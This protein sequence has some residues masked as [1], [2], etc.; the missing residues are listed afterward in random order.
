MQLVRR[1]TKRLRESFNMAI[2]IV[3]A[4]FQQASAQGSRS[5]VLRPLGW[6]AS[7]CAGSLIAL[8]E[9]KAAIWLLI[10][11]AIF[12]SVTVALYL[13][14]YVYCLLTDKE[15]LRTEKYSIQKM[16]IEKGYY[17]D[18]TVGTFPVDQQSLLNAPASKEEQK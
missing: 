3:R 12:L 8:V 17:G 4:L 1:F 9:F 11:F 2:D 7:I 18:S 13:W 10:L 15:A 5:T 6:L 14:A 16:A